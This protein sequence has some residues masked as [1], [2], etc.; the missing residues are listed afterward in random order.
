MLKSFIWLEERRNNWLTFHRKLPSNSVWNPVFTNNDGSE[1]Q[2][3]NTRRRTAAEVRMKLQPIFIPL[4]LP[5]VT[6]QW[7]NFPNLPKSVP[8]AIISV[9]IVH[10]RPYEPGSLI[11]CWFGHPILAFWETR[12]W[13]SGECED[14]SSTRGNCANLE[15]EDL[16]LWQGQGLIGSRDLGKTTSDPRAL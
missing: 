13:A 15:T 10:S 2:V 6:H 4:I 5:L 14:K 7:M 3:Q 16:E 9:T 11:V 8:S 12:S 1:K